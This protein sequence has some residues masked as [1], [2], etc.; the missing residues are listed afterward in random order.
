M[1]IGKGAKKTADSVPRPAVTPRP[2]ATAIVVRDGQPGLEV[3]TVLRSKRLAVAADALVFPGGSVDQDDSDIAGPDAACQVAALRETFEEAGLLLARPLGGQDFVEPIRAQ[4]I[5]QRQRSRLADRSTSFSDM[6][7][8]EGLELA[9]DLLI[10]TARWISPKVRPR[11]F[12]TH[13]FLCP[14]APG[15][16]L[17]HDGGEAVEAFWIAPQ[18]A[19]QGADDGRF[20]VLVP[21]RRSLAALRGV[22]DVAAALAAAR[23]SSVVTMMSSVR[24][25]AGGEMISVPADANNAAEEIFVPT[26]AAL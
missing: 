12:D 17:A 10:P 4:E 7:R 1:A 16:D 9:L 19:L 21:T 18:A 8:T 25:V 24:F 23:A 15:Q 22:R 6:C 5:R 2:A 13:F 11:R 20:Q 26:P 3:L 14:A